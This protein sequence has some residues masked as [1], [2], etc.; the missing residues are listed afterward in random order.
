MTI[1]DANKVVV[2][3][4]T[5]AARQDLN[6]VVFWGSGV[7]NELL[8]SHNCIENNDGTSSSFVNL[9]VEDVNLECNAICLIIN[10]EKKTFS[11]YQEILAHRKRRKSH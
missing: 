1:E 7:W 10:G 3:L 11:S 9:G 2:E 4:R 8:T 6:G 5:I